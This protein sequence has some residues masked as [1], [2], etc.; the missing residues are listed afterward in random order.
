MSANYLQVLLNQ[1]ALTDTVLRSV[2]ITQELNQHWRCEIT[3]TRTQ[4]R[5]FPVEQVLGQ[6]I[7]VNAVDDAGGL[8]VLFSGFVLEAALDYETAGNFVAHLTGIT[9]S[10]V[11]DLAPR[12]AYYLNQT[13][14]DVAQ[15]LISNAGLASNLSVPMT[16]T[17][18]YVQYGQTDFS[19]VVRIAD[20][21]EA[22][23]RPMLQQ[24]TPGILIANSFS[25]GPSLIWRDTEG[26]LTFQ[27]RGELTPAQFIGAHYDDQAMQ[28]GTFTQQSNPSYYDSVSQLVNSAASG[29]TNLLP[30]GYIDH[31]ARVQTLSDFQALLAKE[32]RRSIGKRVL[33]HGSSLHPDVL[34]GNT[35]Q[36]SGIDA[37]GTYGVT[38]VIH[39]WTLTGG[40]S[41]EFWCTPWMQ[42]TQPEAPPMAHWSGVVPARVTS[43]VDP[44]GFG[45]IQV[46]FFWQQ[47]GP[48]TWLRM[49]TPNAGSDRGML[50][51][52][53]VGDEVWV[54]FEDGDPERG[55]IL[56]C[57]W[58]GQD[59]PPLEQFLPTDNQNNNIKRI[60]TKSGTR[61]Q[62]LDSIQD[63]GTNRA[64]LILATPNNN[65]ISLFETTNSQS[66]TG[67]AMLVL[68]STG[69]ILLSAPNGRV[70]IHS[71]L[72]SRE[73]G[74]AS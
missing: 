16:D 27:I 10:Y 35:V 67:D 72:F 42:Y 68:H 7:Q 34:P 48:T 66:E 61:L 53:E 41:N 6:S 38:K 40:Y 57:A 14:S 58:N 26:L 24:T 31:R 36:I 51:L 8:H 60:V 5:R 44:E 55:R 9:S 63:D 23:L 13:G 62:M 32:S 15:K 45:R 30:P 37:S 22:W 65:R 2:T 54:A 71:K 33:C 59:K 18:S 20:D 64:S 52:P 56:G 4:D 17:R 25:N 69:D 28:S 29:S 3:C 39:S 1:V 12:Q 49:M 47:D 74:P 21:H 19:F 73:V 43:N 70:H 46:Q 50:F 11:L